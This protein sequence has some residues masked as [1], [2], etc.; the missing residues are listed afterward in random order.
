MFRWGWQKILL[1]LLVVMTLIGGGCALRK[2]LPPGQP[3]GPAGREFTEEPTIS[4]YDNKTK[5]TKKIK[6]EEYVA[7]VVAAEMDTSWP[8]N[9]LGAQAILARTFTLENIKAG[10]VKKLYGADISTDIE[11]SQAYA[12][13]KIN[14]NVRKAVQLTRGQVIRWQGKYVKAWFHACCGGKTASAKEGLAYEKEP[15]PYLSTVADGCM[16]IT[17]PE[18][19]HW[20]VKLS[21]QEL[22]QAVKQATG[23]DPGQVT[24]VQIIKRGP[25]G[26]VESLKVGNVTISGPALRLAVGSEKMRSMMLEDIQNAG[27]TFIFKGRGFGHGVGLCQWGAKKMAAEGKQPWSIVKFYYKG[28]KIE[29]LW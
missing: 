6:L 18:N 23:Q 9:A 27:G 19:K 4:L 25:S 1:S 3:P 29:K 20:E 15:T 16:A 11:E 14:D 12:P 2:P 5:Q 13:E 8:V 26:R 28:V 17:T 21:G 10:R 22:A 24:S 7:G